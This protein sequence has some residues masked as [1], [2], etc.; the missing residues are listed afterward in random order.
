[1]DQT[2]QHPLS[3]YSWSGLQQE[4]SSWIH[5]NRWQ[6]SGHL[7]KTSGKNEVLPLCW[8]TRT[9]ASSVRLLE[10]A[11]VELGS[12]AEAQTHVSCRQN[13][14]THNWA[15]GCW[16]EWTCFFH[17]I[18]LLCLVNWGEVL[19]LCV[20][21]SHRTIYLYISA[22]GH[23]YVTRSFILCRSSHFTSSSTT[24]LRCKFLLLYSLYS[25]LISI[26][27][28]YSSCTYF[29]T[30]CPSFIGPCIIESPAA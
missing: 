7:Y 13:Q 20:Y 15:H 19:E 11:E 5:P 25:Q 29:N 23:Y 16:T 27:R 12:E 28:I 8:A 6:C 21:S 30:S 4:N 26:I 10:E 22:F 24:K 9:A 1:M 18:L 2:H 14:V 3:F 17:A